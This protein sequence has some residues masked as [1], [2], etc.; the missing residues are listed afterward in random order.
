M[1]QRR[2]SALAS[3][4]AEPNVL[5]CLMSPVTRPARPQARFRWLGNFFA[6]KLFLNPYFGCLGLGLR[7]R[8]H[9]RAGSRPSLSRRIVV[10]VAA[11]AIAL[12][13]LIASF[14]ATQ[15]AAQAV[16]QSGGVVLCHS[17]TGN[18]PAT[19]P[20]GTNGKTCID[21]CCVGCLGMT[22]ALPPPAPVVVALPQ[23]G[24]PRVATLTGRTLV[25][26][27]RHP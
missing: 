26:W 7:A 4:R 15:V 6:T 19:S 8:L 18:E 13:G 17:N 24:N 20:D 25:G 14:G 22:A 1:R 5:K 23:S 9:K 27:G 21:D 16:A 3:Y 12:S 10:L 11:Y 2:L